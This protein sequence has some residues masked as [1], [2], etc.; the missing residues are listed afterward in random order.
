MQVP[1]NKSGI[2]NK[3]TPV[4]KEEG[5][6]RYRCVE[7]LPGSLDCCHAAQDLLGRRFLSDEVPSLPLDACDA[8][9]C[10]C[11]YELLDDRRSSARRVSDVVGNN[12]TLFFESG[13]RHRT[14]TG[15]RQ[16]D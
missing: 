13:K 6:S 4:N 3:R 14:S 8:D 5:N 9:N 7:V 10:R 15:R 11:S 16:D 1:A 12:T 2:N